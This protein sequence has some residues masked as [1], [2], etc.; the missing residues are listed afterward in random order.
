MRAGERRALDNTTNQGKRIPS[1]IPLAAEQPN[2]LNWPAPPRMNL[3][4][5]KHATDSDSVISRKCHC[6]VCSRLLHCPCHMPV[7]LVSIACTQND[8][9]L[10]LLDSSPPHHRS[11]KISALPG[12]FVGTR[13]A[14]NAQRP[15]ELPYQTPNED[16]MKSSPGGRGIGPAD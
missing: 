5:E 13:V 14:V 4:I 10:K 12:N 11:E 9:S 16:V 15:S 3:L 6:S 2:R 1:A 8:T 7:N